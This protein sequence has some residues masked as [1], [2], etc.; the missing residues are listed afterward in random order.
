MRS[1]RWLGGALTVWAY[2]ICVQPSAR[3]GLIFYTNRAAFDA[4]VAG[5]QT[6]TF[7]APS[8]TTFAF[9]PTP[10]GLTLSGVNFNITNTLP[11]DGLNVTG[12][13]F[14]GNAYPE[15][16]LVPSFSPNRTSTQLSITLPPGGATAIGLDYGSFGN[17]PPLFTFALSTGETF[18]ATPAP[19]DSLGFLGFTSTSPITSLTITDPGPPGSSEVP[20]LGDF[21]FGT[22]A[23]VPE[24]SSLALLSIGG[25]ALAGWRRWKKRAGVTA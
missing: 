23:A 2:L 13:N 14:A 20:V 6:I 1:R 11:G 19:F 9:N 3:A 18:T 12:K 22:A 15:D 21:S 25:L 17:N 5:E 8:P 16:F 4:A 7:H 10:P 24:P